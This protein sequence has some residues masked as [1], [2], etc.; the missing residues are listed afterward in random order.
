[1]SHRAKGNLSTGPEA[2]A[3]G[4]SCRHG[5]AS[6]LSGLGPL[7]CELPVLP[8]PGTPR[9][10]DAQSYS[11]ATPHM[12]HVYSWSPTGLR[13][14]RAHGAKMKR[15]DERRDEG[16]QSDSCRSVCTSPPSPLS[17]VK[18]EGPTGPGHEPQMPSCL[19]GHPRGA[20]AEG[21]GG[22]GEGGQPWA[23]RGPR[24]LPGGKARA[25][26]YVFRITLY[27]GS[28]GHGLWWRAVSLES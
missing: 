16:Q 14:R 23:S 25:T 5:Q 20:W 11:E 19:A 13:S 26:A 21:R 2:A 15:K 24:R 8:P 3:R 12:S 10:L 28:C 1:M 4:W 22:A 18:P 9:G 17:P 6:P 27:S 7:V